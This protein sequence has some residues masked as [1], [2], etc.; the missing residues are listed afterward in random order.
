M[1]TSQHPDSKLYTTTFHDYL[2][3]FQYSIANITQ[4]TGPILRVTLTM[5]SFQHDNKW[6]QTLTTPRFAHRTLCANSAFIISPPFAQVLSWPETTT[7]V[8]R[9]PP[10][11]RRSAALCRGPPQNS[12]HEDRITTSQTHRRDTKSLCETPQHQYVFN[13]KF[14]SLAGAHLS[15]SRHSHTN[16]HRDTQIVSKGVR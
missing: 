6:L 5:K 2:Q 8:R 9:V 13:G 1:E 10:F 11:S 12:E 7:T 4:T 14:S 3:Y 16:G 15:S